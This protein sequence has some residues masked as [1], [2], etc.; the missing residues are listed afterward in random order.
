M[1]SYHV[2]YTPEAKKII[3]KLDSSVR[4]RINDWILNNLE[5]CEN[6]RWQGKVLKGNFKRT[7]ALPRGR[8]AHYCPDS[9]R[10]NYYSNCR[11]CQ[12]ERRLQIKLSR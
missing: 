11:R 6:P 10:E 4:N 2:D 3:S 9:R 12:K 5:G 7:L 8:L 1:K